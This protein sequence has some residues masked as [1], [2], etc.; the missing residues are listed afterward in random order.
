[1]NE[2]KAKMDPVEIINIELGMLLTV[3]SVN[4]TTGEFELSLDMPYHKDVCFV[5]KDLIRIILT[6]FEFTTRAAEK[7]YDR[8]VEI[9]GDES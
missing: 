1:M 8:L 4:R 6:D 2:L 9:L 7:A 3:I 5:P